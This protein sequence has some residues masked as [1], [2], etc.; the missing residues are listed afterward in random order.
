MKI[1]IQLL[2]AVAYQLGNTSSHIITEAKQ[3]RKW[4]KCCLR[5]A[6]NPESRLDLIS[7]PILVVGSALMQS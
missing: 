3:A 2:G 6:A 7:Q 5:S 1:Q 4:F